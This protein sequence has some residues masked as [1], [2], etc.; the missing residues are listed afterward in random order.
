MPYFNPYT[1]E[2]FFGFFLLFFQRVIQWICGG[3]M[4]LASDEIQLFILIGV[5]LSSSLVGAFLILRRM[6]MLANAL[7]H[8]ILLGI[9]VA[10]L[11][12]ARANTMLD[13]PILMGSALATGILTTFL[14]SFLSRTLRLQEDASIG[15]IFTLLFALGIL[16]IT[17]FTRNLHI[18]TELVM[19]NVDALQAKDLKFIYLIFGCNILLFSFLY[20][21][22]K[23]T[24]FDPHLARSLGFSPLFFNYLLMVQTSMTVIGSFR[25]VGVLMLLVFITAP[26][27]I[28]RLFVTSLSSLLSL[29]CLTGIF[30]T[31]VSVALSRHILS[32]CG[33]GL[34]T[35]GIVV[36]VLVVL[37]LLALSVTYFKKYFVKRKVARAD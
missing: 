34:S 27:L 26:V 33:I 4:E 16:L 29:S 2:S 3:K 12:M 35:G 14:T 8:T 7:S 1:G 31:F 24:T 11:L 19:G 30:A 5:A 21:G 25:A 13:I 36:C 37:Y 15:L 32:F 28:A 9:V 10:F 17:C 18:G 6:T 20:R 23:I 22:F